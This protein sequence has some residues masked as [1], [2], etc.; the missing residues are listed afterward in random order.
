MIRTVVASCVTVATLAAVDVRPSVAEIYRP[1]CVQYFG[2][3]SGTSSCAF[4]S[5]AQCMETARG[6]GAYCY[7]NPTLPY[8]DRAQEAVGGGQRLKRR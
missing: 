6:N 2:G 1:W 3:L 7:Q 8:G 5:Y 4:S